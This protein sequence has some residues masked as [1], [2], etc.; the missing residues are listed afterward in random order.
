MQVDLI[1]HLSKHKTK[2]VSFV[3]SFTCVQIQGCNKRRKTQGRSE[4]S[5]TVCRD[6]G[7]V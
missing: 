2:S 4:A 6:V 5:S 3:A 1:F 7:C